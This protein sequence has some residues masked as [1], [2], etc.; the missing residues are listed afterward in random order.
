[1]LTC[2]HQNAYNN[3]RGEGANLH[4]LPQRLSDEPIPAPCTVSIE[5]SWDSL[6]GQ[7]DITFKD[8]SLIDSKFTIMEKIPAKE[9]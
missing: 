4:P 9:A 8:L 7:D 3:V 6:E 5:V 1:M 2:V